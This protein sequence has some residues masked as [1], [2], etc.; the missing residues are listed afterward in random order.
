MLP[1]L[2]AVEDLLD[3]L[4]QQQLVFC[5]ALGD[6]V[7]L[8]LDRVKTIVE[9]SLLEGD[10]EPDEVYIADA[11]ARVAGIKPGDSDT[12]REAM[13]AIVRFLD[14][15][16][17]EDDGYEDHHAPLYV[18]LGFGEDPDI[19][20]FRSLIAP[21][22]QRSHYWQGRG[23]RILRMVA[24]IN[25]LAGHPVDQRQLAVAVYVHDF[26]M[27]FMPLALLHKKNV[28]SDS[29]ILL[30]RSHVQSSAHLL[31]Y[32][33]KWQPAREIILQHHEA[34]NG[35]GYPYGLRGKEI[36]DGAKILAIADT[37]DALTHQRAYSRHQKR[38]VIRALKEINEA[39][40][41]QLC[42]KW[43]EIFNRAVQPVLIAHRASQG[44][45][46]E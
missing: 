40:G 6:V 34:E 18:Q 17:V 36:C 26:G 32:M 19:C 8:I 28:L 12:Q 30:L 2:N 45:L 16:V 37:F 38:P 10:S 7:L 3:M 20:F 11:A 46:K 44:V 1:L 21:V 25:E 5:S 27:A 35:S 39:A 29:E 9:Q 23:D 42:S 31:Q 22:E 24:I 4:R 15:S 14:P 41:R 13:A 33:D 43:V